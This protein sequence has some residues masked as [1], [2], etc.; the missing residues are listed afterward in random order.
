M[1]KLGQLNL[2]TVARIITILFSAFIMWL[3]LDTCSRDIAKMYWV[4]NRSI[5]LAIIYT[6]S[7]LLT[8]FPCFEITE[9]LNGNT[10]IT[11]DWFYMYISSAILYIFA[12]VHMLTIIHISD[13]TK[14]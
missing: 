7:P 3:I 10:I 2:N 13:T 5:I 11:F 14:E 9:L 1:Y 12:A 8:A 4:P 6:F